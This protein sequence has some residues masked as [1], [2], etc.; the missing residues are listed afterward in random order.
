[1]TSTSTSPIHCHTACPLISVRNARRQ[2]L[3]ER[4]PFRREQIARR[5]AEEI[6]EILG[7]PVRIRLVANQLV[8]V[9][10]QID[11][12]AREQI[13]AG[14]R[15]IR[16]PHDLDLGP[17][18]I[19]ALDRRVDAR[20]LV[21]RR[22]RHPVKDFLEQQ[23]RFQPPMVQLD[24]RDLTEVQG[25]R[26]APEQGFGFLDLV[27]DRL[28]PEE[29]RLGLVLAVGLEQQLGCTGHLSAEA[30]KGRG[31]AGSLRRCQG[32]QIAESRRRAK[33]LQND[34]KADEKKR[35][36]RNCRVFHQ[37]THRRPHC[38][39]PNAPHDMPPMLLLIDSLPKPRKECESPPCGHA[40]SCLGLTVVGSRS[41]RR[42]ATLASSAFAVIS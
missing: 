29:S 7:C 14:T 31:R 40:R 27:L 37:T 9:R 13:F 20:K 32:A 30:L 12:V 42:S 22:Q 10:K 15:A 41:L 4:E 35:Q 8:K 36:Q 3:Y 34:E 23:S 39:F 16:H 18:H 11:G 5:L 33:K 1:M 17:R 2:C 6:V 21:R 38:C 28:A 26:G 25:A 24:R 19:P